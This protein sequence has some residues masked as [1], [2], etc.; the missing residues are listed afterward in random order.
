MERK[1]HCVWEGRIHEVRSAHDKP[2][3]RLIMAMEEDSPLSTWLTAEERYE[4]ALGQASWRLVQ[5]ADEEKVFTLAVRSLADQVK[6]LVGE[7]SALHSNYEQLSKESCALRSRL[8][9]LQSKLDA[10]KRGE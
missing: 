1:R 3:F 9:E 10:A 8:N 6:R 4:D 5:P 7:K 2:N